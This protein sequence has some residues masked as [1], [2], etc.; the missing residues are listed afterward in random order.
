METRTTDKPPHRYTDALRSLPQ[1]G[2]GGCHA[3]LLAVANL[4]RRAGLTPERM[5]ADL[6]VTVHG[7]RHVPDSEIRQAVAKAFQ[8]V[9]WQSPRTLPRRPSFDAGKLLRGIMAR[10]DGAGE[11]DLWELSPVRIDWPPEQDAVELLAKLYA[12]TDRLFIGGRTDAGADHVC[13][14]DE[15]ITRLSSGAPIPEHITPNPLTGEQG[16]TKDGNPSFRAD[17]CV[18]QFRFAVLEFDAVPE[19]LREPGQPADTAWPRE[20]QAQFWA[21]ALAFKWPVAALIDSGGKSIH[22]WLAVDVANAADWE[23]KVEGDLFA[24]ILTPCGVDRSCRN[25][26]RLSR[27]PGH[28]REEKA[29]WQRLLYMNPDAGKRGVA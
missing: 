27:M 25:E 19:P 22:C 26:S 1:S 17:S 28:F 29:R 7:K 6:R 11:A 13:P 16:L 14:V 10:G 18:K 20:A 2:G 23:S 15:W 3:A 5:F 21:G 9:N 24:N 12:D 8:S 4:G